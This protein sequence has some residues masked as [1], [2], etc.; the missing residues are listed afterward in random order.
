MVRL[1]SGLGRVERGEDGL[2]G[3]AA[4]GGQLAAGATD[5]GGKGRGPGVL[6]DEQRG[7]GAGL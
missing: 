1:L 6:E 2:D 7:G 5:C 4:A 3:N